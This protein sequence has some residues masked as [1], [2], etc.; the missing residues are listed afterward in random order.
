MTWNFLLG[1]AAYDTTRACTVM[2]LQEI[3]TDTRETNIP[4]MVRT[5]KT[6]VDDDGCIQKPEYYTGIYMNFLMESQYRI[7]DDNRRK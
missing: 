7:V 6:Q 4:R 2:P 1:E 5:N 3:N